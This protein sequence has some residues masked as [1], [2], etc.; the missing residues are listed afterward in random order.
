MAPKQKRLFKWK[1]KNELLF[2]VTVAKRLPFDGTVVSVMC[3]FCEYLGR[4]A[5]SKGPLAAEGSRNRARTTSVKYF[6]S[7]FRADN[8]LL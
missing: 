2:G 4:E 5:V 6:R 1:T 3:L 8:M 7:P